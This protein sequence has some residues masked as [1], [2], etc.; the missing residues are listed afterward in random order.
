MD[1]GQTW[2]L[3]RENANAMQP[4]TASK[5]CIGNDSDSYSEYFP[6]AIFLNEC[7]LVQ[8]NTQSAQPCGKY[9]LRGATIVKLS[10]TIDVSNNTAT[11]TNVYPS[12]AIVKYRKNG[13]GD[14]LPGSSFTLDFTPGQTETQFGQFI[15]QRA[16]SND[17][18]YK[19]TIKQTY[20]ASGWGEW[21]DWAG[22]TTFENAR[23]Y[24]ASLNS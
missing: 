19:V 17:V 7:Y 20:T 22:P 8:R 5:F 14:I 16:G 1:D 2:T 6:G 9:I 18:I 15:L 12:D 23:A 21:S 13:V 24:I 4:L 11:C 10:A 3:E